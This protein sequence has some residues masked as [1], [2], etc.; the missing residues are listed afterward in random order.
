MNEG[1][2]AKEKSVQHHGVNYDY[3]VLQKA[4]PKRKNVREKFANSLEMN[5]LQV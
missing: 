5:S 4:E 2:D 1:V 3:F